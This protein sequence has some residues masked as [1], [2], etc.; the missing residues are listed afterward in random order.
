M[1][2][3]LPGS[4]FGSCLCRWCTKYWKNR[5]ALL[6]IPW[7]AHFLYYAVAKT[8]SKNQKVTT[9]NLSLLMFWLYSMWC[10]HSDL[11]L[12]QKT[13]LYTIHHTRFQH[14]HFLSES[15]ASD[16]EIYSLDNRDSLCL[17]PC[18][19]C[20]W[21]MIKCM[22]S[23]ISAQVEQHCPG[24]DYWWGIST[25]LVCRRRQILLIA[26]QRRFNF[27]TPALDVSHC[28]DLRRLV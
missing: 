27:S 5:T 12:N 25:V 17:K 1:P 6:K 13:R 16:T 10:A 28:S 3:T 15:L 14:C 9:M 23:P 7:I 8:P 2:C 19:G 11:I 22:T 18:P 24:A 20:T 26:L 21:R 4:S